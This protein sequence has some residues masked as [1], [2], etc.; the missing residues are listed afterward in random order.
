MY[1][2]EV[3]TTFK[4]AINIGLLCKAVFNFVICITVPPTLGPGE[5]DIFASVVYL[6]HGEIEGAGSG[7]GKVVGFGSVI[8]LNGLSLGCDV[9]PGLHAAVQVFFTP[10]I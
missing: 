4:S 2:D 3:K 5:G 1:H 10:L 9:A 6:R 8:A 7:V